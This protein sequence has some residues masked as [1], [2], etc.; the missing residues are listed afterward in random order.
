MSDPNNPDVEPEP[1]LQRPELIPDP[2]TPPEPPPATTPTVE[3]YVTNGADLSAVGGTWGALITTGPAGTMLVFVGGCHSYGPSFTGT[4][5]SITAT[6]TGGGSPIAFASIAAFGATAAAKLFLYAAAGL[7]PLTEYS[8]QVVFA[9]NPVVSGMV[10]SIAGGIS[11]GVPATSVCPPGSANNPTVTIDT[12]GKE[13]L[14]LSA[15]RESNIPTITPGAGQ[16][17][18]G[19]NTYP[20]PGTQVYADQKTATGSSITETVTIGAGATGEGVYGAFPI[21]GT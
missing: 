19:R 6:P 20:T 10:I 12:A 21:F 15:V 18:I 3:S 14:I 8:V 1:E 17:E 13:A 16:T 11:T 5:T 7:T 2:D 4:I 9:G